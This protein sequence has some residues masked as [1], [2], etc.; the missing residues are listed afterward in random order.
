NRR[1][2][3]LSIP[4]EEPFTTST[5][6]V[7]A[8]DLVLLRIEDSDGVVGYGEAAPF[9]PYDGIPL[10]RAVA[11]LT[12]RSRGRRPPQARAA[13]EMARLDLDARRENRP[14]GEPGADA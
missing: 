12:R 4:C 10:E 13:V 6:V 5:G 11:T 9:E 3:R 14:V 2:L 8:R 7:V 1:L